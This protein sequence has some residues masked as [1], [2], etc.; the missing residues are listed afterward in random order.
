MFRCLRFSLRHRE[1]V[2]R[3][4]AY[5]GIWLKYPDLYVTLLTL[6]RCRR[7]KSE[8]AKRDFVARLLLRSVIR[9]CLRRQEGLLR[10]E[11][12]G[13]LIKTAPCTRQQPVCLHTRQILVLDF[14]MRSYGVD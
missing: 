3:V 13:S 10:T 5:R 2:E 1:S 14:R 8:T 4:H 9:I 6:S 12:D 7:E 11:S